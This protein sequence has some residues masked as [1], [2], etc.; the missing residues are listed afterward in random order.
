MAGATY[1]IGPGLEIF[2]QYNY[3]D[4]GSTK[5]QLDLLPADLNAKSRQSIFSLGLRVPIGGGGE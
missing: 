3:R 1:K 2:G 4:A 5:M